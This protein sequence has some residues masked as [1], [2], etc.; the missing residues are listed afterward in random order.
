MTAEF[1]RQA[2]FR[3]STPR[4]ALVETQSAAWAEDSDKTLFP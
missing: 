1:I 3:R 4:L 2:H